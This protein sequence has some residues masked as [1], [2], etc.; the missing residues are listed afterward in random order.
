[1]IYC[2]V[3][4]CK[5]YLYHLSRVSLTIIFKNC[6]LNAHSTTCSNVLRRVVGAS[7]DSS[8]AL[9]SSFL[10]LIALLRVTGWRDSLV[11]LCSAP[12]AD[13]WLLVC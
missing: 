2:F 8:L 12:F 7:Q 6:G 5:L 4:H 1:M 9:K 10:E 13:A 3:V 11:I